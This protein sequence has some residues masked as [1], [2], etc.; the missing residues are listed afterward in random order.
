MSH[1]AQG[2]VSDL[3]KYF[4]GVCLERFLKDR[5]FNP[6]HKFNTTD[7]LNSYISPHGLALSTLIYSLPATWWKIESS[8]ARLLLLTYTH[9]GRQCRF[10]IQEVRIPGQVHQD[11]DQ[12]LKP[13]EPCVGTDIGPLWSFTGTL[14]L[15]VSYETYPPHRSYDPRCVSLNAGWW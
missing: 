10:W 2:R 1:W 5:S 15:G 12:C 11:F 7:L 3:D 4:R 8:A 9:T 14:G 6:G 13:L